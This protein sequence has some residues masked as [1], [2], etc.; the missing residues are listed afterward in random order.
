MRIFFIILCL[1][2]CLV[3]CAAE[4]SAA[5]VVDVSEIDPIPKSG[6][7]AVK[8]HETLYSIAWQYGLDYRTIAKQNKLTKPYHLASGEKIY[9]KNKPKKEKFIV[10]KEPIKKISGWRR[11]ANGK[12]IGVYSASNKGI[13]IAGQ[14]GD[15][16]FASA[17][18]KVVYCGGGLKAY[19]NLI[20]IKH[21]SLYLTAYA[22]NKKLLV[23]EGNIVKA[24][25]KIAEMGS[26][27]ARR[28]MLHFEIRKQGRPVNPL[29]YLAILV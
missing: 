25:Q 10:E 26:T 15:P 27:G 13:N 5:P 8:P 22:H 29:N 3:S 23:K 19:G 18:G 20:I 6:V 11:P 14:E 28:T 17:A 21:N 1:S 9:L 7:H 16:V 12:I 24:G 2:C 4:R